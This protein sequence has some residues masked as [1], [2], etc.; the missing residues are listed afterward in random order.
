MKNFYAILGVL[1]E[2]GAEEIKSSYRQLA[3]RLHPDMRGGNARLFAR[4]TEAYEV[5]SEPAR[6]RA[7]D[8]AWRNRAVRPV[9][10]SN[11]PPAKKAGQARAA[12]P[13]QTAK[14]SAGN[15][16]MPMLTRI[17]S[18]TLPKT[19]R[20]QIQG[21]FGNIH[22]RPTSLENLWET[23]QRKYAA[24][25][26]ERLAQHVIQIKLSGER[27]LVRT[28][29]PQPT[30]FGVEFQ[31]ATPDQ[32]KN[33]LRSF[34]ENLLGSSPLGG[35]F[36]KRPFGLYGAYLP[37]RLEVTVPHGTPL[38]LRD[39]TG[40]ISVDGVEGA[41]TAKLLG[42]VLKAS[43]VTKAH[44]T[45]NGSSKAFISGLHGPL[46]VMGFGQSKLYASG[47]IPRM[48]A[49][50][51]NSALAEVSA[52]VDSLMSEVNG[53]ALLQVKGTVQDAR[54]EARDYAQV[55]LAEV[56]NSLEGIRTPNAI[57]KARRRAAPRLSP[58]SATEQRQQPQQPR[59]RAG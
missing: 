21:L 59:R 19:G 8:D 27:D 15:A 46:D 20:F 49:I 57:V 53:N 9:P 22:I 34:V 10:R 5:L 14:K 58:A 41:I 42:G 23:T 4:V 3:K 24:S 50:L 33:R 30:D 54:C 11:T 12:K 13:A 7:Y 48:R 43:Q 17:M 36:T 18:I 40:V 32:R 44:L 39:V 6:R 52:G 51:E 26:P 1:P 35:L 29:M 28:L 16:P 45:L 37:L 38:Y 55:H 25:P 47:E 2:A 31:S 56:V